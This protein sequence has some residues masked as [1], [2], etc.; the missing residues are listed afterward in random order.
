MKIAGC[1]KHVPEGSLKLDP[2]SKR[3]VRSGEAHGTV[4]RPAEAARVRS[5]RRSSG[6][7]G[8]GTQTPA[9]HRG[10][11]L[12]DSYAVQMHDQ[13]IAWHRAFDVEAGALETAELREGVQAPSDDLQVLIDLKDEPVNQRLKTIDR[14]D[15]QEMTSSVERAKVLKSDFL[16]FG[17]PYLQ[18]IAKKR[19][20]LRT[21]FL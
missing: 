7:E 15:R 20:L 12:I 1:V 5:F 2:G 3:L 8:V 17:V 19:Y 10:V 21:Y 16:S 6:R 4:E 18:L 11:V 14:F 9:H 13:G